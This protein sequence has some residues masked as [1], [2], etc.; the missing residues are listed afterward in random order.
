MYDKALHY[1]VLR[2]EKVGDDP[3]RWWIAEPTYQRQVSA[4]EARLLARMFPVPL[5]A[6]WSDS[7][8]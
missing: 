3:W 6:P 2:A 5:A 4:E 7:D 1:P 8:A